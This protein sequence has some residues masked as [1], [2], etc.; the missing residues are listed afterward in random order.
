MWA[1]SWPDKIMKLRLTITLVLFLLVMIFAF[2]N[3]ATVEIR[4]LS[5]QVAFP[6]SL[7]IFNDAVDWNYHRTVF[8]ASVSNWPK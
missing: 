3:T 4:L 7:L 1:D 6:R 5:W 2:Q 8:E